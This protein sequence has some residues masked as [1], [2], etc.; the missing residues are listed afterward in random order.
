MGYNFPNLGPVFHTNYLIKSLHKVAGIKFKQTYIFDL[1]KDT[2]P[3]P[4]SLRKIL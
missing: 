1:L 2:T 4:L 3:G